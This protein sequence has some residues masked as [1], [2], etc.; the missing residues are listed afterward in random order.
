M[1]PSS[2]PPR[3]RPT[4]SR[5]WS[6]LAA[7]TR[8]AAARS[9]YEHPWDDDAMRAEADLAIAATLHFRL[10]AV[11]RLPVARRIDYLARAVRPDDGLAAS[12]LRA[13]HLAE[14]AD[15]LAAFLD[16][17]CIPHQGGVID[18]DH[19]LDLTDRARLSAAVERVRERFPPDD[20]AVYLSSLVALDPVSWD[21]LAEF[22]EPARGAGAAD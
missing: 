18:P 6:E 3:E 13:L 1:Q 2:Q 8:R 10:A 16:A 15:L 12:L 9:V 19:A 21:P 22:L 11:R 4:P 5:L 7:D 14:R 20:V 17:L